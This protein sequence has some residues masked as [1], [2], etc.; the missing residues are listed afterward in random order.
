MSW[1]QMKVILPRQ[2]QEPN[3]YVHNRHVL[4]YPMSW[5]DLVGGKVVT[6]EEKN[7]T[8]FTGQIGVLVQPNVVVI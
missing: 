8:C 2:L 4:N 5:Q 7:D 6:T 1:L 3:E